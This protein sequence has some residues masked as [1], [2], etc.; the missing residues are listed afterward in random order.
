MYIC[1][2]VK[3]AGRFL[4]TLV[5][6]RNYQLFVS[7]VSSLTDYFSPISWQHFK[8]FLKTSK[9][10]PDQAFLEQAVSAARKNSA[11]YFISFFWFSFFLHLSVTDC[12]L[13][14]FDSVIKQIDMSV[15][16]AKC[17]DVISR[18]DFLHDDQVSSSI[19]NQCLFKKLSVR[20]FPS[21]H[22]SLFYKIDLCAKCFVFESDLSN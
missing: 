11:S 16:I 12:Q 8:S 14:G 13:A 17:L 22:P 10:D 9:D 5:M 21:S 4:K 18:L 7:L 19:Q 15:G 1:V 2:F 6:C 20:V 3:V